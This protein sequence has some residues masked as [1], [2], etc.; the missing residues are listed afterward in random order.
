VAQDAGDEEEQEEEEEVDPEIKRRMELR[1]RMAKMS[2][3]MG[4][5]GM[6]GPPG[7]MPGMYGQGAS[8]KAKTPQD[9][10]RKSIDEPER[11]AVP[12][13]AP[14]IPLMAL[15]GMNIP[16]PEASSSPK[17][18][19]KEAE[20][21]EHT[22]LTQLHSPEELPDVEDVAEHEPAPRK[23]VDRAPPPPPPHGKRSF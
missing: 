14:P 18:V 8:K 17:E 22:P 20:Q 12:A 5:M 21:P 4:M 6:F 13:Q 9:S 23:S 16:R 2:G 15:P 19:E 11:A 7:G 1:E 10:G 3:G